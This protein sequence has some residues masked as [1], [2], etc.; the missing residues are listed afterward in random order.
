M[1]MFLESSTTRFYKAPD[2]QRLQILGVS[3]SVDRSSIVE[4]GLGAE[5]M[6]D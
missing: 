1:S 6:V 2:M 5:P 4:T 3:G